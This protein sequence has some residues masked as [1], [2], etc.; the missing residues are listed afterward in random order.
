QSAFIGWSALAFT[1]WDLFLD[2][3][4][5]GWGLWVWQEPGAFHFF[6]IPWSNYA[7]WLLAALVLTT[8]ASLIAPVRRLPVAPL[9]LIYGITWFLETFGLILFWNQPGPGIAGGVV[10]GVFLLAALRRAAGRRA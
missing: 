5:V 7:G 4:M 9:L 6:G 10:M 8:A 1:A 3:Q 2:P